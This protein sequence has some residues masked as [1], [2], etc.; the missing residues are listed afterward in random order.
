MTESVESVSEDFVRQLP[1]AELHVH[2][3]GCFEPSDVERLARESGESLPRPVDCLFDMRGLIC[4][5]NHRLEQDQSLLL[6][7]QVPS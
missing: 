1:K 4:R 7:V 3:E 6:F 5:H 2:L